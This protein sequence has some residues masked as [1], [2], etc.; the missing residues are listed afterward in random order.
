L[1]VYVLTESVRHAL[2]DKNAPPAGKNVAKYL[3]AFAI[4]QSALKRLPRAD[5]VAQVCLFLASDQAPLS[6]AI[7]QY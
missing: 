3:K 2:K 7:S 4:N 5:E 1:S 6:R